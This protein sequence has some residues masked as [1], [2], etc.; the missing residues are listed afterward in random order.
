MIRLY[1]DQP[2]APD[3]A[4]TLSTPA[5][6]YLFTVMRVKDKGRLVLFNGRDG[7]WEGEALA[8][9]RRG[10]AL[11]ALALLRPQPPAPRLE[12]ILALIKRH[13]LDA[14]TEKAVELGVGAIRLVRTQRTNADHVNLERLGA[15]ARE[16][17]EQTGRL[18]VPEVHP[19]RPLED[20]LRS[21]QGGAPLVFCDEAGDD[22][23]AQWG[24]GHGRAPPLLDA[25]GGAGRARG[26]AVRVLIGPEGGFSPE[27]RA[28]LRALPG[29][30]PV[31][32][33]PRILRADTAAICALALVQ[34]RL[35]DWSNEGA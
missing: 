30:V 10:G 23:S 4:I 32:L 8:H 3:T 2:L 12:L 6:H 1:V 16:A 13:R 7:E 24:G 35:G 11:R 27:E 18:E 14:A 33:G 5:Q 15:I 34:A 26:D 9:G 25:L 31:S 21:L 20:L 22:P 29:V 19:P 28:T 17:A